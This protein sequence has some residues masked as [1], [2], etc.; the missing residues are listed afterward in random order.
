MMSPAC[1]ALRRSLLIRMNEWMNAH[2]SRKSGKVDGQMSRGNIVDLAEHTRFD[3]NAIECKAMRGALIRC[4]EGDSHVSSHSAIRP[5]GSFCG[6]KLHGTRQFARHAS[7]CQCQR[8]WPRTC[9]TSVFPF[10]VRGMEL[11]RV[12]STTSVHESRYWDWKRLLLPFPFARFVQLSPIVT[13][14]RWSIKIAPICLMK[15]LIF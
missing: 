1:V 3:E 7:I 13:I 12:A 14:A 5:E 2:V 10:A 11:A 15:V 9:C 8:R 4:Q 6:E